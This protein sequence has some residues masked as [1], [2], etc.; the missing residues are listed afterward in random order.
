MLDPIAAN[1]G[2]HDRMKCFEER[3]EQLLSEFTG[4]IKAYKRETGRQITAEKRKN[5]R[6]ML[7]VDPD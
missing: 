3:E 6:L 2:K 1:V 7:S 4:L 5:N